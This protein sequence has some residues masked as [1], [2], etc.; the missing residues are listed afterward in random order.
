MTIVLKQVSYR[1]KITI[2]IFFF[3]VYNEKFVKNLEKTILLPY[4]ILFAFFHAQ[5]PFAQII[6]EIGTSL[7]TIYRIKSLKEQGQI[8]CKPG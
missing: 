7:S 1:K 4:I 6:K 2:P 5:M 8:K 3:F